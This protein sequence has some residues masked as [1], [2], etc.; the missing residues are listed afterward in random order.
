[1]QSYV[2]VRSLLDEQRDVQVRLDR[3]EK[4]TWRY[5]QGQIDGERCSL[6]ALDLM[7]R[8]YLETLDLTLEGEVFSLSTWQFDEMLAHGCGVLTLI[9]ISWAVCT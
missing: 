6:E 9:D 7:M 8:C 4:T 2:A 1:V 5:S 3:E